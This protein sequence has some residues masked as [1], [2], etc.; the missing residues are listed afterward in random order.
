MSDISQTLWE[1]K[2]ALNSLVISYTSVR[3]KLKYGISKTIKEGVSG[4]LRTPFSL[5]F[6][7]V[8][9]MHKQAYQRFFSVVVYPLKP[10]KLE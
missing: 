2:T 10:I 3:Y 7:K 5:N 9:A 4:M 8:Q 1:Y 6:D